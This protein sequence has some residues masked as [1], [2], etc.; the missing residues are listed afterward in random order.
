V[1]LLRVLEKQLQV[2]RRGSKGGAW[3]HRPSFW[4]K[5]LLGCLGLFPWSLPF[6]LVPAICW[7]TMTKLRL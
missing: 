1:P 7:E 5:Y 6:L 3:L 4:R 2:A